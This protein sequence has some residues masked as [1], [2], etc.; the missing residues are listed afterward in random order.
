MS[1]SSELG[2]RLLDEIMRIPAIDVHS[3]VPAGAPFAHTLRDLLGYHYFTELAHSAGMSKKVI[4]DETH[5]EEMLAGLVQAM[6]MLD[7]TVQYGWMI[8]LAQALFGFEDSRLTRENWQLLDDTVRRKSKEKGRER[9]VMAAAGIEKV[10][11]TNSFDEDLS[12]IDRE[13]FVP[14]LRADPLVFRFSD[15]DVRT[16]LAKVT[17]TDIGEATDLAA[18]LE[19][20]IERFLE[21]GAASLAISLPPHF[22]V[23]PVAQGDLD[24]AIG[25][26]AQGK[27]LS[28]A[29]NE[30][31]QSGVLFALGELCRQFKLPVQVMV[32]AVRDAYRHGVPEGTDLPLAGDTLR[33]LMP[34]LNGFPDVTFLL[35][36]LSDSQ[37]HEL[38]SYGWIVRNVVV[39]GHWWYDTIPAYIQRDLAARLQAVPKTKLIGYYSDM[40]KLEFG[41][42]KFNMYRRVLAD[43][44][45]RDYVEGGRGSESDAVDIARLL[46]RDNARRIFGL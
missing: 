45:A 40:Y 17:A 43:V 25:K 1:H 26:A 8:E 37:A 28:K 12:K 38:V 39:S 13:V 4:A 18:A 46:L 19:R 22:K 34:L 15:P 6:S 9:E 20:L 32:G 5:D 42:P 10:F 24:T 44:L 2:Q 16:S 35:S 30:A 7:N 31:L 3:H 33:T 36:T 41:L 21:F 23:F 29:E 14:S 27:P 11:L